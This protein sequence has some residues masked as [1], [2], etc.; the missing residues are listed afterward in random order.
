MSRKQRNRPI[1]QYRV[2]IDGFCDYDTEANSPGQARWRAYNAAREA[3]YFRDEIRSGD[4]FARFLGRVGS[5][6]EVRR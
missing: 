3:G 6:F 2:R 1:R 4:G 5:V